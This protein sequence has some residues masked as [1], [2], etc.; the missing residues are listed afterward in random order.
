MSL[1]EQSSADH[2]YSLR[3]LSHTAYNSGRLLYE[4]LKSS[5]IFEKTAAFLSDLGK[6]GNA[7]VTA[8]EDFSAFIRP[9]VDRVS[10]ADETDAPSSALASAPVGADATPPPVLSSAE[11]AGIGSELGDGETLRRKFNVVEG[12]EGDDD[13]RLPADADPSKPTIFFGNGGIDYVKG[14]PGTDIL[15]PHPK[16]HVVFGDFD[17]S[18]DYILKVFPSDVSGQSSAEQSHSTWK[19]TKYDGRLDIRYFKGTDGLADFRTYLYSNDDTVTENNF[20][21]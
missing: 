6:L 17:S 12:T 8:L 11:L 7:I 10:L 2:F 5:N 9:Y 14:T 18:R 4:E 19:T 21:I 3:S 13:L 15:V 1:Q 20:I 16:S